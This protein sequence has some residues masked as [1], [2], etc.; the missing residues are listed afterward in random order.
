VEIVFHVIEGRLYISGVP[1][2]ERRSWLANLAA[3]PRLT[4]QLKVGPRGTGTPLGPPLSGRARVID[5]EAERREIL[6]F[7][8]RAWGRDDL[9][10]MVAWSPL[11]EVLLD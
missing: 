6:P 10:V 5:T 8:A 9:E 11:I 4:L 7:V 2:Q 1:R 3:E